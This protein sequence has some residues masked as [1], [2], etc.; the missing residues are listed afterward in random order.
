M[1]GLPYDTHCDILS[2]L[3]DCLPIMDELCRRSIAFVNNCMNSDSF[4]VSSVSKFGV[5][6]GRMLSPIGRNALFC[7]ER[8]GY[9][10][11]QF[12]HLSRQVII[13]VCHGRVSI[14]RRLAA[15]LLLEIIFVREKSFYIHGANNAGDFFD[16]KKFESIL[17]YCSVN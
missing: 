17:H 6:V 10:L 16:R 2:V 12:I 1:W 4:I 13:D 3:G 7:C 15:E 8:Y 14:E 11:S 9:R 5:Y